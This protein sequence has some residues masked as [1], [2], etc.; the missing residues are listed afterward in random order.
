MTGIHVHDDCVLVF[1]E[2][3][4][5]KAYRYVLFTIQ[6]NKIVIVKD[7][8]ARDETYD[9]FLAKLSKDEPCYAAFDFEYDSDD[10]KRGKLVFISWIPDTAKVKPKMIYAGTKDALKQKIE[11]GLVEVQATDASEVTYDAILQ[12]VKHGK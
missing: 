3:K 11:G 12:K 6:D 10:V 9:A 7:K 8:G 5:K 2:L 4:T 1:N